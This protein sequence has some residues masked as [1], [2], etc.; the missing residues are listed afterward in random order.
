MLRTGN[1]LT[2]FCQK[3]HMCVTH[4]VIK[5]TKKLPH[6]PPAMSVLCNFYACSFWQH[7]KLR[8][9]YDVSS[10]LG[11]YPDGDD[12][13]PRT[14]GED[15]TDEFEDARHSKS[16]RKLVESFCIGE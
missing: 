3:S 6:P 7:S 4:V 12:V 5:N 16:A 1:R 2:N 13:L 9:V 8:K 14:I 10:H 11:E 15:S